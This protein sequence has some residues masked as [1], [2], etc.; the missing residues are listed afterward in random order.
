MSAWWEGLSS[1]LKVLYCIAIPSTLILL[2]QTILVMFSFGDGVSGGNPTDTSAMDLSDGADISAGMDDVDFSPADGVD[3]DGSSDAADHTGDFGTLRLFTLQTIV[4]LLTSF[5]WVAICLIAKGMELAPAL[6][7]AGLCGVA[8]MYVVAKIMQLS[9][10]LTE[11]GT[12]NAK[13]TIGEK[14][15]VYVMIPPNREQGGKVTITTSSGFMEL[16]AITDETQ[17][18]G[19]GQMVR[20]TDLEGELLV[21]ESI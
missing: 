7:L 5:S 14:A 4:A 13:T 3:A 20:V 12:F 15:Q 8:M 6:L 16:D 19:V 18:I 10:R 1:V 9:V 21:V 17:S 11:N 2:I